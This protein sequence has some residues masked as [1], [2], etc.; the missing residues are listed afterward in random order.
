MIE[1]SVLVMDGEFAYWLA[2]C[3]SPCCCWAHLEAC[4]D[5]SACLALACQA[6]SPLLGDRATRTGS[7]EGSPGGPGGPR[8]SPPN[9]FWMP[10]DWVANTIRAESSGS[11]LDRLLF[12]NNSDG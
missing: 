6:F 5:G 11:Y 8:Q 1:S 7:E 12:I 9:R 3:I 2:E 10:L 4:S